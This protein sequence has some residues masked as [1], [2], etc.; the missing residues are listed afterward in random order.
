MGKR[1]WTAHHPKVLITGILATLLIIIG[2]PSESSLKLSAK[3]PRL[4][5]LQ[6][7][8]LN[9]GS[10]ASDCSRIDEQLS[11]KAELPSKKCLS[12]NPA[13]ATYTDAFSCENNHT[14]PQFCENFAS[15]FD[16]FKRPRG[17]PY[18]QIRPVIS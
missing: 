18:L 3:T 2:I 4:E 13:Y 17:P 14:F 11:N 8:E 15:Y 16:T 7:S 1:R 12:L 10:D 9:A 5:R 6:L